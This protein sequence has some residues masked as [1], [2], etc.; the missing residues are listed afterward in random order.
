[1]KVG[2]NNAKGDLI[3]STDADL[4]FDVKDM[5]RLISKINKGYDLVVGS[6]HL[7]KRYYEKPNLETKIKG[8]ISR[9][10]N[11]MVR[12]LSGE[13]IHDFS[14][15][16]RVIK[17]NIWYKLKT[18]DNTNSILL[19]MILKTKYKGYKVAEIPVKFKDR[20]YGKSKL[21]LAKEA[22]KFL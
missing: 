19:E 6:R 18:T 1:M 3:L 4:S 8:F 12:F 22:P 10:G 5:K 11:V 21:N 2:Y 16:F 7:Y 9:Y 14:A 15:N 13:N 17:N 20:K